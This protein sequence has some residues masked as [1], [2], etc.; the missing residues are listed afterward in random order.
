MKTAPR[1]V[2][3][4][5]SLRPR[6]VAV[7]ATAALALGGASAANAQ[8][9][10]DE[11]QWNLTPYLWLPTIDG[12]VQ[13]DVPPGGGGGP[14]VSV[15][16]TDWLDFLNFGLLFSG[17]AT[18]DRIGFF[19][20]FLYLDMSGDNDGRVVSVDGVIS[21]PGGVIEIPVGADLNVATEVELDGLQWML[22]AGY[23]F[24]KSEAG[25]HHVIAGFRLLSVDI[26]TGWSLTG[27]ITAPGGGTALDA[28]GGAGKSVEL[29]DGIVGLKGR[30]GGAGEGSWSVPYSLDVGAGDSDLVWNATVSL[31]YAFGWGDLVFGYRH[32]EYDEGPGGVLQDFS[33]SG[34]GVGANFRF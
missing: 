34:P 9:A 22:A 17:S 7:A 20:D 2:V 6:G 28:Q 32:L 14:R 18:K 15:G 27:E 21:G 25:T 19:T 24:A 3:H 16:P 33:F 30:F 8:S 5:S 10:A 11:W 1:P 29:W 26:T 13:H 23:A 4:C 12:Q 31:A